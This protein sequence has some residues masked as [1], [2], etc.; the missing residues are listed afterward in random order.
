MSDSEG[1]VQSPV[2]NWMPFKSTEHVLTKAVRMDTLRTCE[3]N[4]ADRSGVPWSR[5]RAL[6]EGAC[7]GRGCLAEAQL[8]LKQKYHGQ[9]EPI[10]IQ[11]FC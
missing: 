8:K 1:S 7:L 2:G 6:V 11:R 9:G 5:G 3:S 10:G 4:K